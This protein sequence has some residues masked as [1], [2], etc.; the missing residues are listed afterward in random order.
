MKASENIVSKWINIK[1]SIGIFE[2]TCFK[3]YWTYK[4]YAHTQ[5][6]ALITIAVMKLLIT[7]RKTVF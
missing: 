2:V 5:K 7:H 1:V 6:D 3:E 4:I